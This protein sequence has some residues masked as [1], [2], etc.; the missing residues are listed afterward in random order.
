MVKSKY[1][2]NSGHSQIAKQS[3]WQ[4]VA[5]PLAHCADNKH[6]Q[7][8]KRAQITIKTTNIYPTNVRTPN[9]SKHTK[10]ELHSRFIGSFTVCFYSMLLYCIQFV[11]IAPANIKENCV[12]SLSFVRLRIVAFRTWLK[13]ACV[14]GV[15]GVVSI[16]ILLVSQC[17]CLFTA[18]ILREKIDEK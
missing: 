11:S 8:H 9:D 7:T 1:R 3:K 18:D 13:V 17:L 4:T 6:T 14:A 5:M 2:P 12:H 10:P 16:V 15:V